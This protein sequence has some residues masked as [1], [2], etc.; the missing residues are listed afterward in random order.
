MMGGLD[1]MTSG[2]NNY[3]VRA[4]LKLTSHDQQL[5]STTTQIKRNYK[6]IGFPDIN[7][8]I[9][10]KKETSGMHLRYKPVLG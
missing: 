10:E 5:Q 3:K 8:K 6:S 7:N 2:I 4:M 1:Q 9:D